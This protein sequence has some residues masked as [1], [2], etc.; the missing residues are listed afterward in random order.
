MLLILQKLAA[1]GPALTG[2]KV[3]IT[4]SPSWF[5]DRLAARK[6][7]YAG[8]F[9]ALHAGEMACNPRL[10]L[11]L[12]RDVAHRMLQHPYT[13]AKRPILRCALERLASGSPLD[14]AC[15][16]AILPLVIMH[17]ALLRDQDHWNVVTYLW[18]H[19]SW[20]SPPHS[21]AAPGHLD[22]A[23]LHRQAEELYRAHSDNNELGVD[24]DKWSL[25]VHAGLRP[26]KIHPVGRGFSR[27]AR[28]ER[29]MDRLGAAVARLEELGAQ[30]LL[31]NMPIH[32]GWYDRCGITYAARRAYY[33]KLRE[34]CAA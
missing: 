8:N 4:L 5:F 21:R 27:Q 15:Y 19:P 23:T 28:A 22:W 14:L 31:M 7:G 1:L 34:L 33:L 17:N 13:M 18:Q 29:G 24:N 6:D 26:S 10:S 2:R 3:V 20:T 11:Q 30:A 32:G 25:E 9:S 16:N 12:K